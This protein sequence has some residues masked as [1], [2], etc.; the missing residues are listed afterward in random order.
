MI[1][2]IL[3][4]KYENVGSKTCRTHKNKIRFWVRSINQTKYRE[5]SGYRSWNT[6]N[7]T[8]LSKDKS[9]CRGLNKFL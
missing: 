6:S 9:V 3:L 5:L 2:C 4:D 8:R 7:R 1:K